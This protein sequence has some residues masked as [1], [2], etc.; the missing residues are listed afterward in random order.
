VTT[1]LALPKE[2]ADPTMRLSA[3]GLDSL[4]AARLSTRLSND[5]GIQVSL[6]VLLSGTPIGELAAELS[7]AVAAS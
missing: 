4:M 1:L 7:Q 5:L 2:D 3:L 6:G